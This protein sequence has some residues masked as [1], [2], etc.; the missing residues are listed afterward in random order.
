MRE[1]RNFIFG[2]LVLISFSCST[3]NESNALKNVLL[4]LESPLEDKERLIIIAHGDCG[5]CIYPQVESMVLQGCQRV[6]II[7][8]PE[9][10]L[11]VRDPKIKNLLKSCES[12]IYSDKMEVL[13]KLSQ[14][15]GE[16]KSPYVI[17]REGDKYTS[18]IL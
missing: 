11:K 4:E 12:V 10:R 6:V 13:K 9:V 17:Y 7:R 8:H 3:G 18:S 14:L 1:M 16:D 2:F 5:T 15:T